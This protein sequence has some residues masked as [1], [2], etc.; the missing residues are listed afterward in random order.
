M[1]KW[2]EVDIQ[3]PFWDIYE[4][5]N[6]YCQQLAAAGIDRIAAY[7]DAIMQRPETIWIGIR[8]VF[9]YTVTRP[10]AVFSGLLSGLYQVRGAVCGVFH[11]KITKPSVNL[12]IIREPTKVPHLPV[13]FLVLEKPEHYSSHLREVLN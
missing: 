9:A 7:P 8:E 4:G 11:K 3:Q 12:D 10:P 1:N 2:K 6:D 13:L 5:L